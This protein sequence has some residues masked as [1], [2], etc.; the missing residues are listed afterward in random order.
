MKQI[1]QDFKSIPQAPMY[2]VN[3]CGDVYSVR[4]KKVLKSKANKA[5]YYIRDFYADGTRNF[6]RVHRIVAE[7]FIPNP[8]NLPCVNH[9]DGDKMN[10]HVSNLEWCTHSHNNKHAIGTGLRTPNIQVAIDATKKRVKATDITTGLQTEFESAR[11]AGEVL[12]CNYRCISLCCQG[13]QRTHKG[14]AFSFI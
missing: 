8:D 6:L 9:I 5:G 10:N 11:K 7:L 12:G 4:Y 1:P 2:A 13:K 14:Y 3:E